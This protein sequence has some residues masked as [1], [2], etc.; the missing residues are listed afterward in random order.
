METS[1]VVAGGGP[2]GLLTA[3]VLA[4]RGIPVVLFEAADGVPRD[5]RAGTFHPPTLEMLESVGLAADLLAM[6][7]RVPVWQFRDRQEGILGEFDLGLLAD[8]T[9]YPF[10]FNCEQ[11]K[12]SDLACAALK[13][14]PKATVL[15]NTKVTGH[16]QDAD[17]VEVHFEGPEGAGAVRG[18]YLVAGDGIR[19]TV[20]KG[21]SV[22]FPGFTWPER[23]LVFATPHD[24]FQYGLTGSAYIA[25]PQ[26]FCGV[27]KQPHDGPPGIWRLAFPV[28]PETADETALSDDYVQSRIRNFLSPDVEYEVMYRGVYR[29]HQRVAS[30]F[31]EGRVL[32]AGDAAHVNNPIGGMGLNSGLHD[33]FNLADKLSEVI[34]DGAPQ[35]L[36]DLYDRQRRSANIDYVQAQSIRNKQLLEERDPVVRRQRLDEIRAIAADPLRA[37]QHLMNTSMIASVRHAAAIT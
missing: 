35:A 9:R 3:L 2:V 8:E 23:F 15:F 17:G 30:T 21:T 4:R 16:A 37:K 6:G 5:Q 7:I 19:S 13:K 36:L 22:Q 20:R 29:V 10:R 33:A 1:V 18:R 27:F 25:D 32:L 12:L 34:L 28:A 26:E 14:E 31:R 11:Y 24:L